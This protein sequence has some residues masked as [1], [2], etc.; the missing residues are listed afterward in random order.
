MPSRQQ[1]RRAIP[2]PVRR[3]LYE[4]HR[5]R[6]RRWRRA[7]GMER[8]PDDS[9]AALTFDDGPGGGDTRA[10]L[11]ALD[12]AAAPATFFVLGEHVLEQPDLTREIRD[13][14]H[15]LALHG[16]THRR[17]DRF[18][19][20]EAEEE[21]RR[22]AA[23]IEETTGE[24]PRWYR[25]PFGRSS[26]LLASVCERL[27]LTLVYWSAWGHDWEPVSA[28]YVSDM[29]LRDLGPGGIALLHDSALYGRRDDVGATAASVA[30]IATAARESGL[31]LLTLGGASDG[32]S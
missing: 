7:P 15:E 20:A 4:T 24:R 32:G 5:L 17:H 3:R 8:L 6:R 26:P 23:T 25:P 2:W 21:L 9:A 16:M 31:T 28:A 19:R 12:S 18:A 14:G 22:G 30:T 11:D 1:L 27:D 10:V 29:V 13:R